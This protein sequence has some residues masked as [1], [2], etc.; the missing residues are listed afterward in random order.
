MDRYRAPRKVFSVM[1]GGT[2]VSVVE[3]SNVGLSRIE[4]AL[5]VGT[6]GVYL[7]EIPAPR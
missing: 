4:G 1:G 7:L 5:H 3:T 2:V 6:E